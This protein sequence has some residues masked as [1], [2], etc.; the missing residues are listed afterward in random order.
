MQSLWYRYSKNM[1]EYLVRHYWWAYLF[2]PAVWF[3]DHQP[4]I[5]AILFGQYYALMHETLR[6]YDARYRGR[7]LQLTAVYGKLTP[8]L[9]RAAKD[10]EFHLMDVATAQLE[11]AQRK[12]RAND[13]IAHQARNIARMSAESLAYQ[14]DSFDTV[15]VFF[16][17]HEMPAEARRRTLAESL[18]VLRPGGRLLIT[19]YGVRTAHHPLHR[20]ALLR[21]TLGRLEPFLAEFW[22]EDL[23]DV[24]H[25]CGQQHG[26]WSR[27]HNETLIFGGFYRVA[28]FNVYA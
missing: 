10:Q 11:L 22:S 13:A 27:L 20:L 14:D 6:R 28:E 17:L 4:I 18:R 12:L 2:A 16:L 3:F 21:W 24:L 25:G 23:A 19:E 15:I 8:V 5:N 1:P 9:A 7:T 26:K